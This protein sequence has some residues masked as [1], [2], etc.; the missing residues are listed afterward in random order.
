MD[1][2]ANFPPHTLRDYALLADGERGALVGPRGDL[3][4]LCM[5]TW[6]SDAV[7]SSLIGGGGT[8]AITPLERYTWGGYYDERSLIWNSRWVTATGIVESREALALPSEPRTAVVLRRAQCLAGTARIRAVLDL[9]AD[10]GLSAMS[11]SHRNERGTWTGRSVPCLVP[12]VRRESAPSRCWAAGAGPRVGC[13]RDA[14]PCAGAQP[15][16]D[17]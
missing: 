14:R 17:P 13:G 5:P 10:F 8:Y 6:D 16:R 2:S 4:W 15:W 3:A 11:G 1:I 12:L 9:R 7:F